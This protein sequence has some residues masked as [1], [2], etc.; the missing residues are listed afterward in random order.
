LHKQIS[1]ECHRLPIQASRENE[2]LPD[3][4]VPVAALPEDR[5]L[6]VF[7]GYD[8]ISANLH[9]PRFELVHSEDEADILWLNYHFKNFR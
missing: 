5:K 2:S 1:I 3:P 8:V 7:S 9:H 6:K 4:E